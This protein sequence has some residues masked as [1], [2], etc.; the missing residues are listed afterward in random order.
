MGPEWAKTADPSLALVSAKKQPHSELA[1]APPCDGEIA[2][3]YGEQKL[4]EQTAENA[5]LGGTHGM[6][7][8]W[9][10]LD[11]ESR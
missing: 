3:D 2:E 6:R 5:S 11:V 4:A 7:M 8:R 1:E 9:M 10:R